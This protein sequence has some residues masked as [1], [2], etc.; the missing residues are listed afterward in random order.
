MKTILVGIDFLDC[1]INAL[2]HAISIAN[3]AK[4]DIILLWVNRPEYNKEVFL[5]EPDKLQHVVK[6]KFRE[7]IDKYQP[8]LDGK[9]IYKIR[10]GKVY[11]EVVSE[12]EESKADLI[13]IGTHGSSGFEEFWIGS[14]ANK[15]VSFTKLPIITIRGGIDI[16]RPLN[17]IVMP[18]DSTLETRQ[19]VPFTSIMAKMHNAEIFVVSVYTTKV[20]AIR[21]RVNSYTDQVKEYLDDME[22][23]HTVDTVDADNLTTATIE[24]AKKIDANLISIMTEQER[25]TTNLWL[26]SYAQQMVNHSPFPVLSIHPKIMMRSLAR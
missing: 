19:K 9:M 4:S 7:L 8:T 22:V 15:V 12:A 13:I 18:I 25:T 14:N 1:S 23:K 20:R 24:Y 26:G 2:I 5:F 17:R 16:R 11:K 6:E 10:E 3:I 21:S